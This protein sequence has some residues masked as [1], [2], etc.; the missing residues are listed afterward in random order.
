MRISGRFAPKMAEN[1]QNTPILCRL[2][3]FI[4]LGLKKKEPDHWPGSIRDFGLPRRLGDASESL[5][6]PWRISKLSE[7]AGQARR[8]HH[9]WRSS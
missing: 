1:D 9:W 7:F 8:D 2:K 4:Y 6:W 3:P 5:A